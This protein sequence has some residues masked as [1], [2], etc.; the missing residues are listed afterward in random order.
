MLAA[1]DVTA[2]SPQLTRT[3]AT[4]TWSIPTLDK[5]ATATVTYTAKIR[6]GA[7]GATITNAATPAT[8]PIPNQHWHL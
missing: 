6:A 8:R 1:A 7:D 2:T 3:G 5:G 4:L